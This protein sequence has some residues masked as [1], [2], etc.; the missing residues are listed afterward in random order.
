MGGFIVRALPFLVVGAAALVLAACGGGSGQTS[1]VFITPGPTPTAPPTGTPTS[2]VAFNVIV[3]NVSGS[4]R[5]RPHVIV[6]G[7]SLSVAILLDSVNG[8]GANGTPTI[9]NLTAATAGC[10]QSSTQLSCVINVTA[11]VGALVYTLTV[12]SGANGGGSSLGSGNL[13]LTTTAGATVTAPATL[14][15]TVAK[16]A[17]TVGGAALGVNATVPVTVQAED[18]G[19][20]TVL[21]T[22]TSPIALTDTDASGQTSLSSSAS[23]VTSGATVVTLTYA[24]GTMTSPATINASASGVSP[25]NVTPGSF[26]PSQVYPTVNGAT[27]TFAFSITS[28]EGVNGPPT[29]PEPL[30]TGGYSINVATGQTYN[31]VSNLVAV[32][33]VALPDPGLQSSFTSSFYSGLIGYYTWTQQPAGSSLGL[34]GFTT[35]DGLVLTCAAPYNQMLIAP[36]PNSWNVRS[37]SGPCTATNL[38]P[39]GD[40]DTTVRA[41]DG[42]YNDSDNQGFFGALFQTTVNSDGSATQSLNFLSCGCGGGPPSWIY[43]SAVPGPGAA[44]IQVAVTDFG[45]NPIPPPGV[46][47]TPSPIPTSVPNPWIASGIPNGTMPTPLESD[48]FITIGTI[49]SLPAQCAISPTILGSNPTLREA[50]ETI[51]LA[52]PMAGLAVSPALPPLNFGYYTSQS[53]RHF[54]LDG[55]GE[56]CNGNVTYQ[57]S[58]HSDPPSYYANLPDNTNYDPNYRTATETVW[59]YVTATSLTAT[60][61]RRRAASQA[62]TAATYMFAHAP[63]YERRK[64]SSWLFRSYKH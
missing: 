16:I 56:I 5:G 36:L 33:G 22:Y 42:S 57:V 62:F 46:T 24:G 21:G 45:E 64:G 19:G 28:S 17:V 1:F 47:A 43:T 63:M 26:T 44:T 41:A 6:P 31:G 58:F 38:D 55:V 2:T 52:D 11:P 35:S 53:I 54:Y 32:S 37:G 4:T 30:Q 39:F 13:A 61:A 49:A 12:Y 48:T 50:D 29:T 25:S 14:S 15:G 10:Q 59:Q 3:P 9:A 20:N 27:T 23:N 51:V 40:L 34:V 60:S 18:A 7:T 8:T